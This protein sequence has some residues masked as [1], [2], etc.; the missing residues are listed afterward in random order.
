MKHKKK[1]Q[2][3]DVK[4]GTKKE[5]AW[6]TVRDRVEAQIQNGEMELLINKAVLAFA[7][8]MIKKEQQ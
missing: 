1:N 6:T 2:Q 5:A 4:I 7:E 3:L 8:E